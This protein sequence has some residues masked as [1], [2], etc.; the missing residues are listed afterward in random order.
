M[1]RLAWKRTTVRHGPATYELRIAGE[2][3][4]I[5]QQIA[6]GGL[7]FWYGDG[8]NTSNRPDRFDNVRKESMNHF[9]SKW[10]ED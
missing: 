4:A 9:R 7:W 8:R 5:A 1:A 10:K 6:P 2:R 3:L